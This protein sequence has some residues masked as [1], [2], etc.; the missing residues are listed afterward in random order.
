MPNVLNNYNPIFYAQEAL[1]QLEKALGMAARVYRGYEEERKSYERGDT[2]SIRVPGT[3]T[4]KDAPSTSQDVKTSKVNIKLDY[5]K[6]V[7]FGLTDKE[8]AFASRRIIDEHIQP[9]AYALAD[10]VDTSLMALYKKVGWYYNLPATIDATSITMPRKVLAETAKALLYAG[11]VHFAVDSTL[12][13]AF[14]G[15]NIFHQAA[16]TGEGRNQDALLNGTLGT[17]F[18]VEVFPSLNVQSHTSG[19]VVSA[20][21][22]VAG[23]LT[24]DVAQDAE[25]IAVGSL[26]GVQTL[27]AGD[28]FT[29]A[30]DTQR[31]VVAADATLA[32]GAATL[33][34]WPKIKVAAT[35]GAV[36]TF[37]NGSSSTNHAAS[38]YANLMFH[39]RAFALAMA[40]LPDIGDGAGANMA[41]VTDPNSGLSIRSRL[42]YDDDN[43]KVNVTLDVLFGLQCLDPNL[44]VVVRRDK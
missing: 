14:L 8:L 31:Y 12:E 21:S 17:R 25:S 39:R 44:A 13:A 29:I 5:W 40:P 19:T 24:S 27:K 36:V 2:I 16:T 3:F 9:A 35:T 1:L 32:S 22:D 38:Y 20:G 37:E 41:V 33:S 42:A 30:G 26:S 15:L 10:F 23:A 18:G 6:D 34:V 28:T 11:D 4:A 7:K 43:A